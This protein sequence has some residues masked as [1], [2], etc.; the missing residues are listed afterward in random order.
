[1]SDPGS[2]SRLLRSR[3]Q[4]DEPA[5]VPSITRVR[6]PDRFADGVALGVR[7]VCEKEQAALA[8]G[9]RSVLRARAWLDRLWSTSWAH[10]QAQN[11]SGSLSV[12]DACQREGK[13][14]ELGDMSESAGLVHRPARSGGSMHA[15]EG[16]G[17]QSR[18]N[19]AVSTWLS[20]YDACVRWLT[21]PEQCTLRAGPGEKHELGA[22]GEHAGL[23]QSVR[24]SPTLVSVRLALAVRRV[25]A[26][27]RDPR[28][29]RTREA[30]GSMS[31]AHCSSALGLRCAVWNQRTRQAGCAHPARPAR[32]LPK[33]TSLVHYPSAPGL[34]SQYREQAHDAGRAQDGVVRGVLALGFCQRHRTDLA[35]S[36][37]LVHSG[38]APGPCSCERCSGIVHFWNLY[39]FVY[40]TW[41]G[42][43]GDAEYDVTFESLVKVT[44]YKVYQTR[45]S[46][47]LTP[48]LAPH[49]GCTTTDLEGHQVI[50]RPS[51]WTQGKYE[52]ILVDIP[53]TGEFS[54]AEQI[55]V[56]DQFTG[57]FGIGFDHFV[58]ELVRIAIKEADPPA[59]SLPLPNNLSSSQTSSPALSLTFVTTLDFPFLLN[60]TTSPVSRLALTGLHPRRP[61]P[62]P[63][64]RPTSHHPVP[65]TPHLSA[66]SPHLPRLL[67][68]LSPVSDTLNNR[69]FTPPAARW[70]QLARHAPPTSSLILDYAGCALSQTHA[71]LAGCAL[72]LG[73]AAF[74]PGHIPDASRRV[75][76]ASAHA[77]R[78]HSGRIADAS[79][80][81]R[82]CIP[83][84]L[85]DL[86]HR[87]TTNVNGPYMCQQDAKNRMS[88][89][90][91]L[92]KSLQKQQNR[93]SDSAIHQIVV[94]TDKR[95]IY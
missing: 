39:K 85:G 77:S 15:R 10:W 52:W 35:E 26:R 4:R 27:A 20:L 72:G 38:N 94:T 89:C 61:G 59:E 34:C 65:I 23:D 8:G 83:Y 87:S 6:E 75:R 19:G 88:I 91:E 29:G 33:R 46:L 53:T 50:G 68:P 1:M 49:L 95:T 81:H 5:A 86:F 43:R 54:F 41:I 57:G 55:D 44:N 51:G 92:V 66:K 18:A 30:A 3:I 14:Q 40:S 47:T 9:S 31:P 42:R 17:T 76:D 62:Q 79:G 60:V 24:A 74:H 22:L 2:F 69:L 25:P 16:V 93:W 37:S 90:G 11:V 58:E 32:A 73:G 80:T 67:H 7:C 84:G 63:R 82:G 78:T 13:M 71:P 36:T 28:E 21:K 70:T 56:C 12:A 45:T 64:R 48:Q